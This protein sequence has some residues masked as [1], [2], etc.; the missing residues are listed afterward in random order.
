[1]G[2]SDS[3]SLILAS[4]LFTRELE[5]TFLNEVSRVKL[6]GSSLKTLSSFGNSSISCCSEMS[7]LSHC[8]FFIYALFYCTEFLFILLSSSKV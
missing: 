6:G 8:I 5:D 1:M 3:K 2:I 7:G 4:D